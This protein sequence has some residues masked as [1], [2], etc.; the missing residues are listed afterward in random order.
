MYKCNPFQMKFASNSYTFQIVLT[1]NYQDFCIWFHQ[2]HTR[3]HTHT[4]TCTRKELTI[5]RTSLSSGKTLYFHTVI[6]LLYGFLMVIPIL[7]H[8][9]GT[10]LHIPPPTKIVNLHYHSLL[11]DN[12]S[13]HTGVMSNFDIL[14]YC[15]DSWQVTQL[16]SGEQNIQYQLVSAQKLSLMGSIVIH[17]LGEKLAVMSQKFNHTENFDNTFVLLLHGFMMTWC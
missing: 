4:H 15:V 8:K 16:L 2:T 9:P 7:S 11:G 14:K 5:Q 13:S 3:T 6:C 12:S 17:H 1:Q 10:S